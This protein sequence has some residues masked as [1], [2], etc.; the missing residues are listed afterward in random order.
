MTDDE[1]KALVASNSKAIGEMRE[2]AEKNREESA[3]RREE[4][5]KNR[6]ESAKRRE[7]SAKRREESEKN[8]ET[9]EK[10]SAKRFE[11]AE[12]RL[13]AAEKN[14]EESAK[15]R[16][17]AEKESAKRREESAKRR[18]AAEKES[19][20]RFEAAEKDRG[21]SQKRFE[22]FEKRMDEHKVEAERLW[23]EILFSRQETDRVL[24]SL[25]RRYGD[26]G[27][28]FGDYTESMFRPSLKRVLREQFRM[29]TIKAPEHIEVGGETL[30]IDMVGH[31]EDEL[32][33]VYIVEIKS[34]LRQ[35]AIDQLHKHLRRFPRFFPKHR[36]KKLFGILAAVQIPNELRSKVLKEGFYLATV[37]D[38]VF[39][40]TSP[41]GFEPRT[42]GLRVQR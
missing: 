41:D 24:T 35:D 3:K 20:K 11:A 32:D 7:E 8:R 9:A 17:T 14:R 21:E 37:K 28:A 30:E 36:G 26:L 13:E 22:A 23:Q 34:K 40:I 5:E 33:E 10:E 4:S 18:E 39:E 19:A 38:D 25:E 12:K 31:A 29:T 27:N 16:E 15:R 1:L 2:A 42:F 6:E